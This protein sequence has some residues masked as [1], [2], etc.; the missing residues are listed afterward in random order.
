MKAQRNEIPRWESGLFADRKTQRKPSSN[1]RLLFL[2][3]VIVLRITSRLTW[4]SLVHFQ[5]G[6]SGR[7]DAVASGL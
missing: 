6:A 2:V 7:T 4:K 5:P 3:E 1:G